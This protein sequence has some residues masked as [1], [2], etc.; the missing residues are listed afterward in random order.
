MDVVMDE[1]GDRV[2]ADKY[3]PGHIPDDVGCD[4]VKHATD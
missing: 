1:S 3:I 4:A 2:W